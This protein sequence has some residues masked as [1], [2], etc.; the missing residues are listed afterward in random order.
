MH[1]ILAA[2]FILALTACYPVHAGL[3][4]NNYT[5]DTKDLLT[6]DKIIWKDV[7]GLSI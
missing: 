3:I 5:P 6:K 1:K 4:S 7:K 2:A